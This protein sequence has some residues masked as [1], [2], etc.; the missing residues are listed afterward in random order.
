MVLAALAYY[1][2]LHLIIVSTIIFALQHF[3]GYFTFPELICGTDQYPF[4]LLMIH[5][6]FLLATSGA[7]MIQ[8]V[9]RNRHAKEVNEQTIRHQSV[10]KALLGNI[11]STTDAVTSNVAQLQHTSADAKLSANRT[12]ETFSHIDLGLLLKWRTLMRVKAPS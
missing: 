7:L 1:A 11:A 5:A 10:I 6:V 12:V 4:S 2:H 3:V 9:V 8:I